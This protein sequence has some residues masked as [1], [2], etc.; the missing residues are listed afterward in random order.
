M[1]WGGNNSISTAN[2]IPAW[3]PKCLALPQSVFFLW[4]DILEDEIYLILESL[5]LVYHV[6][7]RWQAAS[8]SCGD[9]VSGNASSSASSS[10]QGCATLAQDWLLRTASLLSGKNGAS[11]SGIW[12]K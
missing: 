3:R 12:A 8:K 5:G 6:E 2:S 7:E 4:G 1:C 10:S 11:E 9:A